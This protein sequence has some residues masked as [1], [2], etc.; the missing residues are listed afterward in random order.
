MIDLTS[1]SIEWTE[2]ANDEMGLLTMI[3]ELYNSNICKFEE[4]FLRFEP[5]GDFT[6]GIIEHSIY[7]TLYKRHRKLLLDIV[8]IFFPTLLFIPSEINKKG[9]SEF[10][11]FYV[12]H[13]IYCI[14]WYQEI[15]KSRP[16]GYEKETEKL[17]KA[18]DIIRGYV[19]SFNDNVE[20][21]IRFPKHQNEIVLS[22][23]ETLKKCR[24]NQEKKI[25]KLIKGYFKINSLKDT[26]YMSMIKS[27][28]KAME[29]LEKEGV[30]H[31]L[32][33]FKTNF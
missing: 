10:F 27:N 19:D 31:P 26:K 24:P 3:D 17:N 22:L 28:R 9:S 1:E 14:T 33:S 20:K 21:V 29:F 18:K 12:I 11:L 23:S 2:R 6:K 32:L 4:P 5:R 16:R 25:I 8:E 15:E 13:E 7:F 30:R